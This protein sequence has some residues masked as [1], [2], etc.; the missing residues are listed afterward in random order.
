MTAISGPILIGPSGS[1]TAA[2]GCGPA[3]AVSGTGASTD[4]TTTV[5]LSAD[6]PDL[7]GISAGDV[8]WV[9]TT[10]GRQF[11]VI[12]SVDD[13]LD[14]VTCDVAFSTTESSRNW[15][16]GGKRATLGGSTSLIGSTGL[17]G[18]HG[19]IEVIFDDAHT[20]TLT[21][22][23]DFNLDYGSGEAMMLR[24]AD[25]WNT[26][27][28]FTHN[29]AAVCM[30]FTKDKI[31]W[32]DC[33]FVSTY[34]ATRQTF[35]NSLD[36]SGNYGFIFENCIIGDATD[37][38]LRA[39]STSGDGDW[40]WINCELKDFTITNGGAIHSADT[41]VKFFLVNTILKNCTGTGADG[42]TASAGQDVNLINSVI[43]N[44]TAK[45][46][47][48][49]TTRNVLL[50][51]SI[52]DGCGDDGFDAAI[53]KRCWG[54][55]FTNNGGYGIDSPNEQEVGVIGNNVFYNNTSG[56]TNGNYP[57]AEQL[58]GVDQVATADP[59]VDRANDDFRLNGYGQS[60]ARAAGLW[61]FHAGTYTDGLPRGPHPLPKNKAQTQRIRP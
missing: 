59:Y 10:S 2:S 39:A 48:V 24:A 3:S 4:G 27:P 47:E 44:I 1:N 15:G 60:L 22:T 49:G 11:S 14:T 17:D 35:A 42:I 26:R 53:I 32:R 52:I 23:L 20:E 38:F 29:H 46:I 13:G 51:N 34:S 28:K 43:H 57:P 16:I 25:G 33:H 37:A 45:G 21:A 6:T 18:S 9:D 56:N 40:W 30:T 12:A 19:L 50:E 55:F 36:S 5:D 61:E 7:S 41:N 58:A 31:H 8:L 54:C